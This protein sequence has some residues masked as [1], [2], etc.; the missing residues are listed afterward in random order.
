M[1]CTAISTTTLTNYLIVR[2]TGIGARYAVLSIGAASMFGWFRKKPSRHREYAENIYN[3][4]VAYDHLGDMTPAKLRIHIASYKRYHEKALLQREMMC[5]TALM[6]AA[7]PNTG[8]EFQPVMMEFGRLLIAKLA[9]RGIQITADDLVATS[10]ADIGQM[11]ADPFPWA[12]RWLA[13]FRTKPNENYMV[14]MFADH[15]LKQF[16]AFKNAIETTRPK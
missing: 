5:F 12:Q 6:L 16:N 10:T 1:A 13:E 4:L 7:D 15:S 14:A 11:T 3:G 9:E 2:H 8:Q